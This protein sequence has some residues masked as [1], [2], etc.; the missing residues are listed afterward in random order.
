MKKNDNQNPEPNNPRQIAGFILIAFSL[1]LTAYLCTVYKGRIKIFDL[2]ISGLR[3]FALSLWGAVG[4]LLFRGFYLLTHRKIRKVFLFI[5][6]IGI[7]WFF[8]N[9]ILIAMS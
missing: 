4:F 1:V 9:F 8:Y 2:N 7:I 5:S 3:T 6:R